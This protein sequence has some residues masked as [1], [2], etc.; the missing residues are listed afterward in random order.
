MSDDIK[1]LEG[2]EYQDKCKNIVFDNS[3][4]LPYP[5]NVC[6]NDLFESIRGISATELILVKDENE[7]TF[8]RDKSR[9]VASIDEDKIN[10]IDFSI[11]DIKISIHTNSGYLEGNNEYIELDIDSANMNKLIKALEV[12]ASYLNDLYQGHIYFNDGIEYFKHKDDRRLRL[13]ELNRL[14]YEVVANDYIYTLDLLSA[15]K[16]YIESML[17]DL[18]YYFNKDVLQMH[19]ETD[20]DGVVLDVFTNDEDPFLMIAKDGFSRYVF[21]LHRRF[22]WRNNY[23][24][25]LFSDENQTTIEDGKFDISYYVNDD[26]R[27][28]FF[29]RIG[30]FL[31]IAIYRRYYGIA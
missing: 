28:S 23:F 11:D 29:N 13:L 18:D 8:K 27:T 10:R 26:I 14:F 7:L 1:M 9:L 2:Y 12:C 20:E 16:P 4:M 15:Y 21:G 22:S 17:L 31:K 19:T 25:E 6:L 3:K 30:M 24:E 5:F